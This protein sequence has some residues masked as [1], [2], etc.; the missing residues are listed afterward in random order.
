MKG[1]HQTPDCESGSWESHPRRVLRRFRRKVSLSPESVV[2]LSVAIG[3]FGMV[4][5]PLTTLHSANVLKEQVVLG[6]PSF[7]LG[8]S[9]RLG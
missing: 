8:L 9:P 6:V 5:E 7:G 1:N 2:A 3:Y 4:S